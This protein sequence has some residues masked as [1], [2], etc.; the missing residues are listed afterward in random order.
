MEEPQEKERIES[1]PAPR[2]WFSQN[3]LVLVICLVA[4]LLCM[5]SYLN[6]GMV[7]QKV[8]A[9]WSRAWEQACKPDGPLGNTPALPE[10]FVWNGSKYPVLD[11]EEW[12]S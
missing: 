7:T 6:A 3:W 12:K 5:V 4:V 9:H 2:S 8:N 10:A 11:K 1:L